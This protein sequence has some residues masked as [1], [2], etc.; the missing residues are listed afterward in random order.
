MIDQKNLTIDLINHHLKE[1]QC[2]EIKPNFNFKKG[3]ILD[4][5]TL[6]VMA[7]VYDALNN[8]SRKLFEEKLKGIH[9][10]TIID[11]CWSSCK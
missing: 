8:I 5:S 11:F 9:I 2:I 6:N 10:T 1:R 7:K 3:L 4:L